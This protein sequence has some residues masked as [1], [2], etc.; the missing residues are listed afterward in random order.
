ML[1]SRRARLPRWDEVIDGRGQ[2][3]GVVMVGRRASG[4]GRGTWGVWR[5][6]RAW[7]VGH[8]VSG[9]RAAG[10]GTAAGR[11]VASQSGDLGLIPAHSCVRGKSVG[12]VESWRAARVP[13]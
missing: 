6:A 7:G 11:R 2:V 10:F 3:V 12:S 13:G 9:I 1:W 4:A 5:R 8:Q